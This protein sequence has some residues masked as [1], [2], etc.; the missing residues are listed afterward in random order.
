M[1]KTYSATRGLS[2]DNNA[3]FFNVH[4]NGKGYIFAIGWTGQW[5]CSVE[6]SEDTITFKSKVENTHFRVM[7]GEKF[8]TSSIVIMP[9]EGNVT[10]SQN[11]WRRLVKEHFSLIGKDGRDKYGPLCASIWGGMKSE[12]VISRIE[13]IKENNIPIE[14]IWMDAGW[15]GEDT[16]PTPDEFEGDWPKH[17]GDWRISP[18]IHPSGLKDVSKAVSNAGM[19]FLLWI[20]PERVIKT[21]PQALAHPEWFISLDGDDNLLLDLGNQQ[22]WNYC[23]DL[24]SG[25]IEELNIRCYRQDFNFSALSYWQSRDTEDRRGI[26]EIKHINGLYGFWDALLEKFPTLIIDNCSAGGRRIDIETLRRSM[27]LWR[28]DYTCPANYDIH[29]VQCHHMTYNTW[30]PY[31]GSGTGREYDQY[32]VRSAYDSSLNMGYSFSEKEGFCDTKEKT[33]FIKKYAC[34]YLKVRPYFSEDFYPLTEFSDKLDT[35]FAV[36][37]DRPAE[38]DGIVQIFRREKS[39]YETANLSL[40]GIYENSDYIFEDADGG[41]FIVSG[42]ILIKEGL[43]INIPDKKTAKL[44][45][46]KRK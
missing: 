21:T 8:R 6:R 25:M 38:N 4:K 46:Y 14:Y 17:T 30:M 26:T 13:K 23:V 33:D 35:W 44:Y 31:S 7:P 28:T 9:Y 41:E 5:T 12:E 22:A 40:G 39:P 3:P 19:K 11:K 36:Q 29:A 16:L 45:F 15:Y 2:S 42:E 27:P 43:K 10:E 37:F 18:H 32:R 34:E 24:V 20:E 1:A